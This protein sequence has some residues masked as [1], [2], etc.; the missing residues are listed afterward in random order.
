MLLS[1]K[2]STLDS[3]VAS[4]FGQPSSTSKG[5][6]VALSHQRQISGQTRFEGNVEFT[7]LNI[8][9]IAGVKIDAQPWASAWN[10]SLDHQMSGADRLRLS[11]NQPLR[12]ES[13]ALS[14]SVPVRADG[15]GGHI[16][17]QRNV[18]LTPSAREI[19]IAADY[20]F[21]VNENWRGRLAWQ[22]SIYPYHSKENE[23][24]YTIWLGF[25]KVLSQ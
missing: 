13:G 16:F 3:P 15:Q 8:N 11:V 25:E 21:A 23:T 19:N 7:H 6:Y 24:I 12:S 17:E 1:K 14:L 2:N 9:Q 18:A 4:R 20:L 5:R 22:S 10:F